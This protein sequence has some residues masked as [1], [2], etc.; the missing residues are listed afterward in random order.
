MRKRIIIISSIATVIILLTL[1]WYF[2]IHKRYSGVMNAMPDDVICFFDIN[3]SESFN[4]FIQHDPAM[5][6]LADLQLFGKLYNDYALYRA[7]LASDPDLLADI[8]NGHGLAG[9]FSTGEGRVDY[10][11]LLD[12]NNAKRFKSKA[13]LPELNGQK[14]TVRTHT[15]EKETVYELHYADLNITLSFVVTNGMLIYSTA[16]VLVENSLHQL[17]SGDPVSEQSSF[18]KVKQELPDNQAYT[19]Y[20]HLP[21]FGEFLASF[22]GNQ[23]YASVM[24]V[25]KFADWI[26]CTLTNTEKGISL[27]GFCAADNAT[28]SRYSG[29]FSSDMHP[30]VPA[31]TAVLYRIQTEQLAER[32]SAGM[33]GEEVNRSFFDNWSGWMG[34]QLIIGIS[35]SLDKNY[36]RRA[37][38]IIPAQDKQLAVS[39][40]NKISIQDTA[41]Y[42]NH[43]IFAMAQG[44]VLQA[45]L[46]LPVP[47]TCFATWEEG[48]LVLACDRQ[49]LLQMIDAVE[50]KGTLTEQ[51]EYQSF[52]GNVSASFNTSI[53]LHLASS[54]QLI[55]QMVS[56]K[57]IDSIAKNFGLLQLFPRIEL[58]FTEHKDM[59]MFNGF[60]SYTA[61]AERGAGMLW[62]TQIDAPVE[63]GPFAVMNDITGIRNILVQDTAHQLYMISGNGDVVWKRPL[64]SA[65]LGEV[66][67]VDFYG[68]DKTQFLFNTGESIFL[69]DVRG[70]AVEGFPITLT[71]RISNPVA[72]AM[73]GKSDY[74]MFVACENK[75]VYGYYK[76]GKPIAGWNPLKSSGGINLPMFILPTS[77]GG[78]PGY[79]DAKSLAFFKANGSSLYTQK[80]PSPLMKEV[81]VMDSTV[82]M[83]DTM[84]TVFWV[85]SDFNGNNSKL[86][87]ESTQCRLLPGFADSSMGVVMLQNGFIKA[88]GLSGEPTVVSEPKGMV[89]QLVVLKGPDRWFYG[90]TTTTGELAL[91]DK[92]GQLLSGFPMP[93]SALSAISD[94][95][96]NG[97]AILITAVGSQL[98][99]YRIHE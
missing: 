16:S 65:I 87:S 72:L 11:F 33:T 63:A 93:G 47:D 29:A 31:N 95:T 41:L 91:I 9:A 66:H 57:Q 17:K 23:Q 7:I 84:R 88:A 69:I 34:S 61:T 24:Q 20:I 38:A 42:R 50:N 14:P 90:Y 3:K 15:F 5:Q 2:F 35:E 49:Q 25:A 80:I 86:A 6:S 78:V 82:F 27:N 73:S 76:D 43:P 64:P 83:L 18:S 92:Q 60:I 70:D 96:L 67:E 8:T 48:D 40:I 30:V 79:I 32:L 51:A 22:T 89:D 19:L 13:L 36:M 26:G 99:A 37:F 75:N 71:T 77:K 39:K 28:I 98:H 81:M 10:L 55:R 62:T 44:D 52:K 94:L 58:Q 59:Y 53:F 56:D 21:R 4:E 1:G 46:H 54:E 68:N 97:D 85:D 74:R 45:I 12:L